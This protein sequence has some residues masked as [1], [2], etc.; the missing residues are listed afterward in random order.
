MRPESRSNPF[1]NTVT[2]R[3]AVPS[4]TPVAGLLALALACGGPAPEP[5][6]EAAPETP[7][8][9]ADPF[10]R[11]LTEADFPRTRELA[12]GVHSYE[13]LRA[14]GEELF[15]TVS[16]FVVTDA[17][18]LVADGQG[19][20]EETARLVAEIGAVTDRPITHVVVASDHG[21]HTAGNAAFP[22]GVEFIV[23]ENS[24]PA[25]E[26][27]RERI[28]DLPMPQTVIGDA[29]DLDLAGRRIEIRF[30][31]R[32]HT[33]G[34]L[35]VYLPVEGVLFLT[36]A[37]LHRIFPAMRSAYPSE[38]VAMLRRAQAI[39]AEWNIPG[40]GFVD[41]P[42][43]LREELGVAIAALE[44]VIAEA[45]RLHG[46]GLSLE[47]AEQQADF[48]D[49]ETWSLRESQ[50]AG[51]IARVYMELNGE[52]PDSPSRG[53]GAPVSSAPPAS[54]SES[55][56]ARTPEGPPM[57]TPD[58]ADPT[59]AADG[60]T[61]ESVIAALYASVSGPAGAA[62]DWARFRSLFAPDARLMMVLPGEDG[63]KTVRRL[64]PEEYES[65]AME[66]RA[67]DAGFFE[68]ETG[69]VTESHGAI[70][71]RFGS[72]AVYR[73]KD[74]EEPLGRGLTTSQFVH[75]GERWRLLSFLWQDIAPGDP[76][77]ARYLDTP[78]AAD[79]R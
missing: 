18:V 24:V 56:D 13:Q 6:P 42:E 67:F 77:P 65:E 34:D 9:T 21:D 69:G 78:P 53:P 54:S 50:R 71:H 15:T 5:E 60:E 29:H 74:D 37:Y 39:G 3:R 31:G 22:E 12:P 59:R 49:L 70:A 48:G 62:R 51:A 41:D 28:P 8:R 43:V 16:L 33:G 1:A 46:M 73:S 11:G 38:W 23:H 27:L 36:E 40:H 79:S 30:L 72:Y 61:P 76:L 14:A 10:A 7:V 68:Y 58:N 45:T 52:L 32:A 20:F 75:D 63:R 47:E 55:R 17:G 44:T 64:T 57:A 4:A 25:M 19:N 2:L 26:A 66:H 35:V